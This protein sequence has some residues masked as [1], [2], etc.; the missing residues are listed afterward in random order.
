MDSRI[1][2]KFL[3]ASVGFGGSCFKKDILNLVYLCEY[4]GLP[5]VANYWEQVVL[6]NEYQEKRFVEK[7]IANM[8]NTITE[9]KIAVFGFAFKADTGDTRESPAIYV[10]E[11]L[12]KEKAYINIYDPE[13][14]KN[15]EK[16]LAH[17]K[18]TEIKY[19]NCPYEG[20]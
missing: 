17:I 18:N 2:A 7:I 20:R 15:A 1:G 19:C 13:A 5:E 10:T 16:D 3:N 12:A 11:L 6:M 14:L 8:F 4:Y 9:K